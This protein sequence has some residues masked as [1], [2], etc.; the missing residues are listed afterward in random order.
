MLEG[1]FEGVLFNTTIE[2]VCDYNFG[3]VF[4][5]LLFV[6]RP[7]KICE[8]LAQEKDTIRKEY[9]LFLGR[10]LKNKLGFDESLAD[11]AEPSSPASGQQE[12]S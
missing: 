6:T 12:M 10:S 2:T 5:L 11:N 4:L 1:F 9:W 3:I 8:N 7:V